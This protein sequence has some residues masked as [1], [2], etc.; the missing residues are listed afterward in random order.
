MPYVGHGHNE[1][2]IDYHGALFR[3]EAAIYDYI[4]ADHIVIADGAERWLT[5]PTEIL[6]VGADNGVLVNFVV[7]TKASATHNA[8]V[9]HDFTFITDFNVGIDES[10]RMDLY[11]GADLGG[12]INVG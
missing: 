7:L 11:V 10:E 1:R 3:V 2:I 12:G 4:F 6:R 9:G 8:G 5:C